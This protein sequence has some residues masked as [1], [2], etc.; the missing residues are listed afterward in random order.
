[1]EKE[2]ELPDS[3]KEP[4]TRGI[5]NELTELNEGIKRYLQKERAKVDRI[6]NEAHFREFLTSP[7]LARLWAEVKRKKYR[8]LLK[9]GF[10][11]EEA[12]RLVD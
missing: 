3:L 5:T 12:L 2:E 8:A 4:I 1:M 9:V 6:Q 7:D 10:T 11:E